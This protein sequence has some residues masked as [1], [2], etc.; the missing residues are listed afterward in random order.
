MK[1]EEQ[2]EV[3]FNCEYTLY[4]NMH[5]FNIYSAVVFA[6]ACLAQ[7]ATTTSLHDILRQPKY[8]NTLHK[9]Q[10]AEATHEQ[11]CFT[12]PHLQ[13][14]KDQFATYIDTNR[15]E[16]ASKVEILDYLRK[17]N[18]NVTPDQVKEFIARRDQD[19]DGSVDF[20]P[21][22]LMEVSSPDFDV[23]SAKEWFN[24]EDTNGDGFVSREELVDIAT[25]VGMPKKE[26]ERTVSGY[27]MSADRNG[28]DKLSW[29]E[30]Q[31]LFL[32][33]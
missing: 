16:R 20:I 14:L 17:Y 30:Y 4:V 8:W 19:G 22:Y 2:R 11:M 10:H 33:K 26:A 1:I 9:R 31:P 18:P 23:K 24:L 12:I 3:F 25:K 6:A 15:D 29:E 21:D 13:A 7:L 32:A 5:S 27:Y 28:D